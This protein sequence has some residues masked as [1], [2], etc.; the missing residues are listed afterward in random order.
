VERESTASGA[1]L[2]TLIRVRS[3]VVYFALTPP[4]VAL[5]A[6]DL[7]PRPPAPTAADYCNVKVIPT[8]PDDVLLEVWAA[9]ARQHCLRLYA[10]VIVS[11]ELDGISVIAVENNINSDPLWHLLNTAIAAKKAPD[12]AFLHNGERLRELADN[13]YLYPL[14]DCDLVEEDWTEEIFPER[15]WAHPFE[16]EGLMLYYSKRILRELG[17][18]Q[19]SID[20]FP[21]EIANG[22]VVLNDLMTIAHHAVNTGVVKKGF[23]FTVH[24]IRFYTAMHIFKLFGGHYSSSPELLASNKIALIK[25]YRFYEQLSELEL[26]HPAISQDSYSNIGNRFSV[27]DAL[28]NGKILFTHMVVSEWKRMLLDHVQ[29][30][31]ELQENIG[32]ALFPAVSMDDQAPG[33]DRGTA[34]LSS[35]GSYS[36]LSEKATGRTNQQAAC[37]VIRAI[38]DSDFHRQHAI[39]TSQIAP[40]ITGIW[41]PPSMPAFSVDNLYP[42]YQNHPDRLAFVEHVRE[43]M[44]LL[45]KDKISAEQAATLT[46]RQLRSPAQ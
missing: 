41:T 21:A 40:E 4:V 9:D 30:K 11:R 7:L 38:R 26:M 20:R 18:D 36:I 39:N 16:I 5:A 13:G 10:P 42:G 3:I 31:S 32:V 33:G 28:A 14:R 12:I 37:K 6:C 27:R 24:E 15:E 19:E 2:R 8:D 35:M 43:M 23:A 17:W 22:T 44:A 1:K 25:T 34:V 46:L 29:N 45:A